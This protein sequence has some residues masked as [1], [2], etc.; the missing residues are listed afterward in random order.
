MI[1]VFLHPL[2]LLLYSDNIKDMY[3]PNIKIRAGRRRRDVQDSAIVR[4]LIEVSIF[5]FIFVK[6]ET[7]I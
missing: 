2:I 6:N 5:S 1:W 4:F 3:R 7:K